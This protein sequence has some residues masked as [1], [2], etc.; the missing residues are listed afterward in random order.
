MNKKL[1][2]LFAII[3][4]LVVASLAIYGFSQLNN[5]ISEK[6]LS[7]GGD[8]GSQELIDLIGTN[9]TTSI[10]TFASSTDKTYWNTT[11][12]E[13]PQTY[14]AT[15]TASFDV[16]DASQVTFN[17]YYDPLIAASALN[18]TI[19]YSS[20]AGCQNASSTINTAN[21]YP[22][23]EI[24]TTTPASVTTETTPRSI[25]GITSA[26][27][28]GITVDNINYRCLRLVAYNNST[29]DASTL[30]VSAMLKKQK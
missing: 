20:D 6:V 9:Y 3:G 4:V 18:Y 29:T 23:P 5:P 27:K 24:A 28:W 7:F 2:P 25:T 26:T 13:Y 11:K 12:N 14:G 1:T 22:L 15:T 30:K 21:W 8:Q 17:F 16:S 19:A 10:F